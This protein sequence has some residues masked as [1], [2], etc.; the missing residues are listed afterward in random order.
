MLRTGGS[1]RS[2]LVVLRNDALAP[3]Q[4]I[5]DH[6]LQ[7][8]RATIIGGVDAI[9]AVRMQLLD[10]RR[11]D[12]AAASSEDADL[13]PALLEQVV[14][15]L[16]ELEMSALIGGDRDRLRVLLDRA[17]HDLL[18]RAV[19]TEMDHFRA[20][21]LENP[22]HHIDR[23]VM[24]IEER[25]G[26]HDANGA[27][28]LIWRGSRRQGSSNLEGRADAAFSVIPDFMVPDNRHTPTMERTL[29]ARILPFIQFSKPSIGPLRQD[30]DHSTDARQP[31]TPS[32]FGAGKSA[33]APRPAPAQGSPPAHKQYEI[34]VDVNND[35]RYDSSMIL[36]F[37]DLDTQRVFNRERVRKFAAVQT[38][39]LRKLLILDAADTIDD[40]RVPPGNRLERLKGD[41][42]GQY[43]IRI[44]DQWRI[45]FRWSGRDAFDVE[46]VDYHKG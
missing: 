34:T 38:A 22:A 14:H 35:T 37:R 11:E 13:R 44:N 5:V 9:D 19:V 12:R 23:R 17:L 15:V 42:K 16:E 32:W 24:P 29:R 45:C 8:H 10:L 2:V 18:R 20:R 6:S 46:V 4:E 33:A 30:F 31:P 25:R 43:S 40:L 26:G 7:S 28:R 3:L 1:V 36:S 27:L 39:A 41:R 21:R